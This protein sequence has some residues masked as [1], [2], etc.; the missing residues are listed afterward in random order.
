VDANLADHLCQERVYNPDARVSIK[1]EIDPILTLFRRCP[2][3]QAE[4]YLNLTPGL[5]VLYNPNSLVTPITT[6]SE[7]RFRRRLGEYPRLKP[8]GASLPYF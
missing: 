4:V 6:H 2:L 7:E 1:S 5:S 8:S 3:R